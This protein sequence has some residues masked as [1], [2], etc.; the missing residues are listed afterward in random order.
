MKIEKIPREDKH[1]LDPEAKRGR[2]T[3]TYGQT[4]TR[5]YL[6]ITSADEMHFALW[7]RITFWRHPLYYTSI[8]IALKRELGNK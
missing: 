3:R 5:T 7:T 4:G 2:A 1:L 8:S 6:C